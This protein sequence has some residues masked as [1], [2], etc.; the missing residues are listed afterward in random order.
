MKENTN[1]KKEIIISDDDMKM[2][3]ADLVNSDKRMVIIDDASDYYD[4]AFAIENSIYR[5][6][7]YN[8]KLN[9]FDVIRTIDSIYKSFDAQ[10]DNPLGL[11]ITNELKAMLI[12]RGINSEERYSLG[13][14]RSCISYLR[15]IVIQHKSPDR[16][17]YLKWI[18]TFFEGKL[19]QTEEEIREY[20]RQNES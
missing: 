3:L 14:I 17:G 7:K 15:K 18:K 10:K 20:I 16:I 9:D 12:F 8:P 4:V 2:P 5:Y 19:P 13:E 1:N 11:A 6:W